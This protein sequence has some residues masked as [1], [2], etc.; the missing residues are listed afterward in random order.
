MQPDRHEFK[1][2][3][4]SSRKHIN[5]VLLIGDINLTNALQKD[6]AQGCRIQTIR[7]NRYQDLVKSINNLEK[8]NC[9]IICFSFY[10][11]VEN[12]IFSTI[13]AIK[14]NSNSSIRKVLLDLRMKD[15]RPIG[16][17]R[18]REQTVKSIFN[19]QPMLHRALDTSQMNSLLAHLSEFTPLQLID[20]NTLAYTYN[21]DI[22]RHRNTPN[23]PL[24]NVDTQKRSEVKLQLPTTEGRHSKFKT[25]ELVTPRQQD[26]HIQLLSNKPI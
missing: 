19:C 10:N 2:Q 12:E 21:A 22:L 14:N 13:N 17:V 7:S 20:Q 25:N 16:L 23:L 24:Y 15:V 18:T 26:K 3:T 6:L 1:G 8:F 4:N 5:N 11:N 9:Y